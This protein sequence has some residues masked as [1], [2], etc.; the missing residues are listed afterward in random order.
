[1]RGYWGQ[2]EQISGRA[3]VPWERGEGGGIPLRPK[4]LE[5][6]CDGL[7]HTPPGPGQRPGVIEEICI[8]EPASIHI[9]CPVHVFRTALGISFLGAPWEGHKLSRMYT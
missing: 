5:N 7:P 1:M 4:A 3:L 9:E 6:N 8:D 2:A